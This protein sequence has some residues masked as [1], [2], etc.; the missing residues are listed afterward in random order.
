MTFTTI[1]NMK[2]YIC[3]FWKKIKFSFGTFDD[4]WWRF[5]FII[6]DGN[7]LYLTE[8]F[9]EFERH[10]E[11]STGT[12][13][14]GTV[15]YVTL[16]CTVPYVI[17]YCTIMYTTSHC[18]VCYIVLYCSMHMYVQNIHYHKIRMNVFIGIFHIHNN[19]YLR[20]PSFL[21]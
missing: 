16:Y 9:S 1:K 8:G 5:V 15:P 21:L 10:S 14:A 7:S 18:T 11:Q 20:K 6:F 17:L 13:T 12:Q 2:L 4:I 19:S 3:C